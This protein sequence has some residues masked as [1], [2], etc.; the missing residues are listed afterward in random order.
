[1]GY[2]KLPRVLGMCLMVPV[3]NKIWP[4]KSS[5]NIVTFMHSKAPK[6]EHS[7]R[8]LD[9]TTL[10]SCHS[11]NSSILFWRIWIKTVKIKNPCYKVI[12]NTFLHVFDWSVQPVLLV[13]SCF[14]KAPWNWHPCCADGLTPFK[15]LRGLGVFTQGPSQS[16]HDLK[17]LDLRMWPFYHQSTK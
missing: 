15:L 10:E 7:L 13:F 5:C 2:I 3:I 9:F 11:R 4:R 12:R 17:C 1:M 8:Y 14:A 16:K 6:T